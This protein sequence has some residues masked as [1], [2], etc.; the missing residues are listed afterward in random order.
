MRK[1]AIHD[2]LAVVLRRAREEAG[3][4]QR[5]MAT[6]LG[7]NQTAVSFVESGTQAVRVVELVEWCRVLSLDPQETLGQA[8]NDA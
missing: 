5:E 2:R 7:T 4:S 1:T 6:R 8:L 3:L